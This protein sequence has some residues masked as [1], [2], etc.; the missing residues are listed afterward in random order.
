MSKSLI[1][2]VDGIGIWVADTTTEHFGIAEK[3][4]IVSGIIIST[5]LS[6][7]T[8]MNGNPNSLLLLIPLVSI[9][10]VGG[11]LMGGKMVGILLCDVPAYR[12]YTGSDISGATIIKT[13]NPQAD[14][15][16]ICKAAKEIESRC[17]EIAAKRAELDRIAAGCK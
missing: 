16:A 12:V 7:L 13:T 2:N 4:V 9:F 10:I 11:T 1:K 3:L 8:I 15:I 14:Q 17:H 6:V 5:I